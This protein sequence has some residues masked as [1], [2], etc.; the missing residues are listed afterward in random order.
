MKE[1]I[2]IHVGQGGIQLGDSC[3]EQLCLEHGIQ[4][5][6]LMQREISNQEDSEF[7]KFYSENSKGNFV[8]RSLFID[9]ESEAISKVKDGKY[10]ELFSQNSFIYGKE[11]ASNNFARGYYQI[12]K[13]Y[14]D[15]SLER[16]RK[17]AED[18]QS[19]QGILLFN[20]VGGG[21]GSGLG[22]LLLERLQEDYLKQIR[23]G[24]NIY[25]YPNNDTA[26]IESY[27]AILATQYLQKFADVCILFDNQAVYGI[28]NNA[29]DI[30]N[31][32]YTNLNRLIAQVYSSLTAA[33]RFNGSLYSDISEFQTNLV[34]H[35][36][37]HF[38]L[39]SYSPILSNYKTCFQQPITTDISIEAFEPQNMMVKC[40]PQKGKFMACSILYR[41]DVIPRDVRL[42][43]SKLSV[44]KTIQFVDWCPTK[45][46]VGIT[47]KDH[48]IIP[49]GEIAKVVRSACMISNT[50][51]IY[52]IFPKFT[53]AF[54]QMFSRRAFV[55]WYLKEGMEEFQ[56]I[57]A[58][59]ELAALE[60]D[61]EEVGSQ[62]VDE[63]REGAAE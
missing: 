40:N 42:S 15:V 35:P 30:Q 49:N 46:K 16:V 36:R 52:D 45:F 43:L 22:T 62:I 24:I 48:F 39:C 23:I 34:L 63:G 20:S 59:E 19:P 58:R 13:E 4:P 37:L 7:Y 44:Q 21:T 33:I 31:P 11:D 50:T 32:S 53:H 47:Y 54:D 41:G 17:L 10:R 60:K 8:P 27:N 57:E 51:A 14:I 55:H 61:Y 6:G 25:P 56:F 3:W 26:I 5:N 9:S 29:L 28:C 1:V 18:C 38:M 12:G 2:S